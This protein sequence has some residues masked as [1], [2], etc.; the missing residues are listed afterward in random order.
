M[1]TTSIIRITAAA[2]A[3][4]LAGLFPVTPTV[5][6]DNPPAPQPKGCAVSWGGPEVPTGTVVPFPPG[7]SPPGGTSTAGGGYMCVNGQWILVIPTIGA[8]GPI[9]MEGAPVLTVDDDAVTVAEGTEAG[10]SGIVTYA[11]DGTVVLSASVGTVIDHGDSTWSWTHAPTDGPAQSQ[12][13]SIFSSAKE[14]VSEVRFTLTVDNVAPTV[15]AVIPD[16]PSTLVDQAVTFAGTAT[17][18][19]PEDEAAGLAWTFDATPTSTG[20]Y[21]TSFTDCGPH[22]ISATAADKDG[23]ASSV[24][25]SASVAVVEA[26]FSAPVSARALNA[27]QPGQVVPI[28]VEIGC[29]GV[30]AGGLSPSIQLLSGEVDPLTDIGDPTQTIASGDATGADATNVMREVG[31]SY[32]YNL[33]VPSAVANSLFTVRVTPFEG[34][35]AAIFAVL[36]IRK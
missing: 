28:R 30:P 10:N 34:S 33:R 2:V 20:T 13:V 22:T 27:V 8:G 31:D 23:G 35:S 3:F 32:Q 25:T 4:A 12:T 19:S 15:T 29:G 7:T 21:T 11:G 18:P 6:E 9:F 24:V 14:K 26:R 16:R 5:A 1:P 17:D 36:K